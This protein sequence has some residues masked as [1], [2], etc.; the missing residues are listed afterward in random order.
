MPCSP[1][2]YRGRGTARGVVAVP[3]RAA[4]A[5]AFVLIHNYMS[6]VSIRMQAGKARAIEWRHSVTAGFVLFMFRRVPCT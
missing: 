5:A 1:S 4:V 6:M 2:A 3:H